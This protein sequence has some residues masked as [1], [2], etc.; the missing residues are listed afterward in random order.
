MNKF[1]GFTQG[2]MEAVARKMGYDGPMH[3]FN[4]FLAASPGKSAQLKRYTE[5]A[6][7]LL[8]TPV[9]G[10]AKG[11]TVTLR[12]GAYVIPRDATPEEREKLI[13][14]NKKKAASNKNKPDDKG[15][16]KNNK[17]DPNSPE[18][19]IKANKGDIEADTPKQTVHEKTLIKDKGNIAT[20]TPETAT[21]YGPVA[22]VKD[23]AQAAKVK[24][25]DA[26]TYEATKSYP[27]AAEIAD[28]TKAAQGTV[29][30]KAIA[31]AA[32]LETDE[33]EQLKLDAPQ[34]DK[35][36]QVK[37]PNPRVIKDGELVDGTSVNMAEVDAMI[38]KIAPA[39]ADPSTQATVQG[40]LEGLMKDFEGGN[41]P[42]WAAGAMRQ[43]QAAMAAR[44][45]GASSMAGMAVV[46][47]AMESAIPI[48]SQ[49][50]STYAQFES[51][52]LSNRQQAVMAAAEMRAQFLGQKFDQDFQKKVFNA[53]QIAEIANMNF[54]ADV[55]IALENAKLAQTVDLANLDAR[56]AKVLSDAAALTQIQ[57]QN[58]NNRQQAALQNA[59]SFLAMDMK[60]LDNKQQTA[61]FKAQSR[62]SALFNDQAAQNAAKQFNATSEN[63]TEQFFAQLQSQ[64]SQFNAAQKNT[65]KATNVEQKNAV[66]MFNAQMRNQRDEFNATQRLVIDQANAKWRQ[67][68]STNNN[69]Q[70]NENNRLNAQLASGM[71]QAAYNNL[72][73]KE[74]DLMSFA[75]TAA[76]NAANR[77]TQL[78]LGKMTESSGSKAAKQE[79][80]VTAG[81]AAF[82]LVRD[83]WF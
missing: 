81:R 16:N 22:Q 4:E 70:Q 75:F 67:T 78:A 48:A 80:W 62:I 59:Q 51:Q 72:W 43:A 73:Q 20:G 69:M 68:V 17:S 76:E 83:T 7:S 10:M 5:K 18:A 54:T 32:Y 41:T 53:S 24:T 39:Q 49:D 44:G 26:S 33:I 1:G 50:A 56:S 34:I 61:L 46:Q 37:A 14:D 35:A 23:V 64:V 29:Q 58:L 74:R 47:A 82:E 3:K 13:N 36:Q 55:Q 27:K 6:R 31:K 45:L 19:V 63:Q 57:S 52:N 38:G 9:R 12:P 79:L 71:T 65:A 25:G 66:K 77:S 42:P 28:A 21:K 30:D 60:N 15:K 11:G 2:Q 8:E 40:Q